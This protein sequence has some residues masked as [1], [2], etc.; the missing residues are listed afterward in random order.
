M[1][2]KKI[3]ILILLSIFIVPTAVF[4]LNFEASEEIYNTETIND[5]YYASGGMIQMESD[6]NGDLFLAGGRISVNS[7]IS[8]DVTIVGGEISVRGEVGD[9][10]R[11]GGGNVTVNSVIK[12]DLILGGGNVEL[13]EKGFVGGNLIIGGGNITINAV[14]NGNIIGGGGNVYINS[15]ITGDVKLYNVDKVRMGPKGKVMGNFSYQSPNKSETVNNETVM[16]AIDYK[17]VSISV[18]DN[19][20]NSFIKALLAGFSIFRLLAILFAGLFLVWIFRFYM[21]NTVLVSYKNTLKS[22][23]MGLLILIV[24]PIVALI[25]LITGI[26]IHLAYIL[27]LLW[28]LM[29]ALANI[30]AI[31]IV[32]MKILPLKERSSFLRAYGSYAIGALIFVVITMVPIIGWVIKFIFVMIGAGALMLYVK[33]LYHSNQKEKKS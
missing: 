1:N 5:D 17:P 29:L 7:Q 32:G 31:L 10:A 24:T 14:V 2:F 33:K 15:Q 18:S 8:Q 20:Y 22:F 27:F 26:G 9:D 6:V 25:S 30:T 4:A 23:G 3:A 19:D 11:I 13:G 28:F 12:D 21:I 16:G